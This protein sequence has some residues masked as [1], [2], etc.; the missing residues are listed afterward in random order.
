MICCRHKYRQHADDACCSLFE[1]DTDSSYHGNRKMRLKRSWF[2]RISEKTVMPFST[3][4]HF[5]ANSWESLAVDRIL[6]A[7]VEECKDMRLFDFVW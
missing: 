6:P 2:K 7:G 1:T 5:K 4:E 3:E